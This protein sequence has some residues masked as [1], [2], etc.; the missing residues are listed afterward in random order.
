MTKLF[1]ENEEAGAGPKLH[2]LIIGVDHYPHLDGGNAAARKLPPLD[3]LHS[4]SISARKLARWLVDHQS[5]LNGMTLGSVDLLV[6]PVPAN[7]AAEQVS[8]G[9][10]DAI[11]ASFDTW[12]DRCNES[13]Q[14]VA[15]F[16]FCGHG[17]Q[18]DALLLLPENFG[19]FKNS[20]WM[21]AIDFDA[22]YLG[23]SNCA[24][25]TQYFIIDACRQWSQSVVHD[26]NARGVPLGRADIRKQNPRIAPTLYGAAT[27]LAAFGDAAGDAS[28][29]SRA[30]IDCLEGKAA[31]KEIEGWSVDVENLGP[32]VKALVELGNRSLQK[33][34]HQTVDPSIAEFSA[35]KRSLVL[36][37]ANMHPKA[38]VEF[39]CNPS[40]AAE[41][42]KFYHRGISPKA[43]QRTARSLG[44][45]AVEVL[46][47]TYNCGVKISHPRFVGRESTETIYPPFK[48]IRVP[49]V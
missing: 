49:V 48:S 24:A 36:L 34:N 27:G 35:P 11:G 42:G 38:L 33:E 18:K 15:F 30:I 10:L 41:H 14:N 43:R 32:A 12:F 21:H 1:F 20:P 16:Y 6:A 5:W 47:G 25:Q 31:V 3:N 45:W 23:M 26:L 44:P 40:E 22:T 46:A 29:L 13:S 2:A 17:L 28:R 8:S 19:V 7:G 9:H 4:P 39:D 37:P